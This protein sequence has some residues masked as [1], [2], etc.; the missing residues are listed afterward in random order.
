MAVLRGPT[1][2]S[3]SGIAKRLWERLVAGRDIVRPVGHVI[4]GARNQLRDGT[5]VEIYFVDR[6]LGVVAAGHGSEFERRG[7]ERR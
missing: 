3:T 7:E 5:S 1:L 6:P 4:I 2:R